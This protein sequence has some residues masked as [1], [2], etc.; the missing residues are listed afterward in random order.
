M[1]DVTHE[2]KTATNTARMIAKKKYIKQNNNRYTPT[3][4]RAIKEQRDPKII[5]QTKHRQARVIG[6]AKKRSAQLGWRTNYYYKCP[7]SGTRHE[8]L[9]ENG[10]TESIRQE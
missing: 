7:T 2:T 5:G 4:G 9:Q 6:M 10:R 3:T 1:E 8:C